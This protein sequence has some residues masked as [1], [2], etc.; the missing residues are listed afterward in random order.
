MGHTFIVGKGFLG[1]IGQMFSNLVESFGQFFE[2]QA[3]H[4]SVYS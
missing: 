1:T 2:Y 3:G 4:L